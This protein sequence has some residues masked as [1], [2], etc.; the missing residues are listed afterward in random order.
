MDV[1]RCKQIL[2]RTYLL[3]SFLSRKKIATAR[4]ERPFN[5]PSISC[6]VRVYLY[7]K[8]TWIPVAY[9][10]SFGLLFGGSNWP[11]HAF[12][13]AAA[14]LGILP[15][16]P[17]CA[18]RSCLVARLGSFSRFADYFLQAIYCIIPQP[19][20]INIGPF[21]GGVM[22]MYSALIYKDVTC[23]SIIFS[24]ELTRRHIGAIF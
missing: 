19:A 3:T 21:W 13:L 23:Y 18:R 16:P 22:Q 2:Q 15:T 4:P 5:L 24:M 12:G 9:W 10:G 11:T 7:D 14:A 17:G 20:G 8:H 1:W 6:R